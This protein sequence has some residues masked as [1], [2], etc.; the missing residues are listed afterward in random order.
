MK[1][2]KNTKI[3]KNGWVC[4]YV[5]TKS[6]KGQPDDVFRRTIEFAAAYDENWK[7]YQPGGGKELDLDL[8]PDAGKPAFYFAQMMI[9][10]NNRK[11]YETAFK[12]RRPRKPKKAKT[13]EEAI[14]PASSS[15]EDDDD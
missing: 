12:K 6:L 2:A 14:K 9:D 1:K 3:E 10:A 5:F 11:Y 15:E 4:P 7:E 13:P 8:L